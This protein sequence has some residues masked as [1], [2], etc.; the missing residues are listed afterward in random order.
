MNLIDF[1]PNL[2]PNNPKDGSFGKDER[3]T[4]IEKNGGIEQYYAIFKKDGCRMQLGLSERV[5]SRSLKEPKSV[6]VRKRFN[7]LNKLCIELKIALDGEFYMHGLKFNEIFRYFSNTDVTSEKYRIKLEKEF[8]KDP[9]KF[10]DEYEGK[11]IPFLTTFHK[12]LKFWLFDGIVLDRPD[13]V[14]YKERMQEIYKRLADTLE[15]KTSDQLFD[16]IELPVTEE[17]ESIEALDRLYDE[18]LELG[19]E[20]LVLTH[21]EHKYKYGRNTIKQG[22]ILKLK[23][24]NREYDGVIIDIEEGTKIKE[25]VERTKNELGRSV[26]SQKKDDREPSGK[27]KGF[28]VQF[29]DKG[30]FTVS[31][32]GFDDFAKAEL[33]KNKDQY[34]G[35]HFKYKAMEPVKDFPRHAH[36][37]CW[38]DAK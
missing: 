19:F 22:T 36:F 25:G 35:R 33:L 15:N 26:T 17:L 14:G 9:A 38:R 23:D 28:V 32:R 3:D 1:K 27:A 20:G 18:A 37:D 4:T 7:R 10:M 13:L 12:G 11:S 24:D 34:I 6:L 16:V 29:E 8:K 30:T 31:L 5:L 2:I 21:K